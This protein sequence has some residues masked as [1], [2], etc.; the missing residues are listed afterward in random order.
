MI[1]LES[2]SKPQGYPSIESKDNT[3]VKSNIFFSKA[4]EEPKNYPSFKK[5]EMKHGENML[6][7]KMM[8]EPK[9]KQ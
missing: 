5:E 4:M 7:T 1:E 3:N 2:K 9:K 6:L 8:E